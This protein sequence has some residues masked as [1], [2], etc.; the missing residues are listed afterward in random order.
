MSTGNR[1]GGQAW[2]ALACGRV[3]SA[4]RHGVAPA[5]HA[6]AV[7]DDSHSHP[8]PAQPPATPELFCGAR[9]LADLLEDA[10]RRDDPLDGY[11]AAAALEQLVADRGGPFQ[12]AMYRVTRQ[13]AASRSGLL[14]ASSRVGSAAGRAGPRL[15]ESSE[16]MARL[17]GLVE[18]ADRVR[19]QLA[20]RLLPGNARGFGTD[21]VVAARGLA[22]V[23]RDTAPL[24][25]REVIRIPSCFHS[26]DQRPADMARL[27]EL[28]DADIGATA[29]LFALVGIRTSGSYLAPLL[30]AALVAR[31][32]SVDVI[33][34]RPGCPL[35]TGDRARLRRVVAAGGVALLIDDPPIS[36]SA[37]AA[38][39]AQLEREVGL[40]RSATALALAAL[41]EHFTPVGELAEIRRVV[42]PYSAWEI[43]TLLA[44]EP[45]EA[46]V[47]A[48][49]PPDSIVA[50]ETLSPPPPGRRGHAS[51]RVRVRRRDQALGVLEEVVVVE[52]VGLGF[53]ATPAKQ[54]PE[55]CPGLYPEVLHATDGV[56]VRRFLAEEERWSAHPAHSDEALGLVVHLATRHE[57]LARA[58][59]PTRGFWGRQ[60]AHEIA[61]REVA[62]GLGPL[63][64]PLAPLLAAPAVGRVLRTTRPVLVDGECGRE[65]FFFA[66]DGSVRKLAYAEGPFGHH[67]L[68]SSDPIFDLAGIATAVGDLDFA[69]A[70]CCAYRE[71]TN[72]SIEAERWALLQLVHLWNA[73][74]LGRLDRS[75]CRRLRGRAVLQLLAGLYLADL[76]VPSEGPLCAFDIDGVL[77]GGA[78][79]FASLSVAGAVALRTARVHGFRPLLASGRSLLEVT[80]HCRLLGLPGAVAEYGAVAYHAGRDEVIDVRPT[81]SAEAVE[82]LRAVAAATPGLVLDPTY[83]YIVRCSEHTASKRPLDLSVSCADA[84]LHESGTAD[85]LVAIHGRAQTDFV[86]REV[87]K[88]RAL[89]TLIGAL[90]GPDGRRPLAF[91]VGDSAP[92]G[93]MLDLAERA[94]APAHAGDLVG[95]AGIEG[96]RRPFESGTA[97]AVGRVVG[98]RAGGCSA[99][100]PPALSAEVQS[101]VG[102][103]SLHE[104]GRSGVP[105]RLLVTAARALRLAGASDDAGWRR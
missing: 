40:R 78:L 91:A 81:G 56:I 52:G 96:T 31:G 17:A 66:A 16:S 69:E 7:F 90:G 36:G 25:A 12:S 32:A 51:V 46:A 100:R 26:F 62:R 14:R 2:P 44:G 34:L 93:P 4:A 13:L 27:G 43:N 101:L 18:A 103:L 97:E 60:A 45:L 70:L 20:S 23:A 63:A 77:E 68:A 19:T 28:V 82:V 22:A 61:A 92:D 98:H 49:F 85:Q 71:H 11:L 38:A 86:P 105:L 37:L 21:A 65:H 72:E 47:R 39:L 10:I 30:G 35:R 94:F 57:R 84:L 55:L 83:R 41:D 99:C 80:E 8:A 87:D 3:A 102:L 73:Q 1:E 54:I 48:A 59:D 88:G 50:L 42:L 29:R 6:M 33:T 9:Q 64:G 95:R 79:G 24:L 15:R 75:T 104:A 5:R 67:D 76:P 89:R 58:S 74:R 53:F